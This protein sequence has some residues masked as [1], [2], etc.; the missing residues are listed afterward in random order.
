MAPRAM[1]RGYGRAALAAVI[2]A[3]EAL[4]RRRM[5]AVIGDS[6]NTGSI[7]LHRALGFT[8]AGVLHALGYKHDRWVDVVMMQA[9]AGKGLNPSACFSAG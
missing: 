7:G 5:V 3:C 6:G 9:D 1:G 2:A 4:G 8:D